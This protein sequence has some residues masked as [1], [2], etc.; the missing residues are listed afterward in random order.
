[1]KKMIATLLAGATFAVA[2]PSFAQTVDDN[3]AFTGL[4]VQAVT[5]YDAISAGS[6]VD[7]DANVDND[8]SAEGIIYGAAVGY[9][10]DL[11]GV[12]IGPEA[13]FTFSSAKTEFEDGDFEGFGL[14]RVSAERDLYLGARVGARVGDNALAYVKGGY[15]NA[16]LNTTNTVGTTEFRDG[17]DLD[18]FRVGGG[19]EVAL[20]Q[21][22]FL[23]AEYR[24]S[25]YSEAEVD[26]EGSVPDADRFDIDLDRHQ[27]AVGLGLRF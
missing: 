3:S 2:T 20:S 12:V 27:V 11:G 5:G 26:F 22:M 1:M 14:G 19:V 13:E 4:R 8:Q 15:T 10:I 17:Y 25:K 21:N 16:T 6:S 23:N 9:D 24:Y 7:D 18:G